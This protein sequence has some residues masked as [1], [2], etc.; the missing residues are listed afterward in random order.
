MNERVALHTISVPER[1]GETTFTHSWSQFIMG[2][3]TLLAQFH[4]GVSGTVT[5]RR[6]LER[7]VE[8]RQGYSALGGDIPHLWGKREKGGCRG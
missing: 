7:K 1:E 2:L 4:F 6:R 5:H 3:R 8:H